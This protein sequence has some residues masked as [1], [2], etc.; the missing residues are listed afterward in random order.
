MKT[1]GGKVIYSPPQKTAIVIRIIACLS[2]NESTAMNILQDLLVF[3]T[4]DK[5][6]FYRIILMRK[7]QNWVLQ[8]MVPGEHTAPL[9]EMDEMEQWSLANTSGNLM[10][11]VQQFLTEVATSTFQVGGAYRFEQSDLHKF[12]AGILI[13][14]IGLL[15]EVRDEASKRLINLLEEKQVAVYSSRSL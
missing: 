1:Q 12:L 9:R 11:V 13:G 14:E 7:K 4:S 8:V 5:I 6:I 15:V 3:E 10:D 2:E